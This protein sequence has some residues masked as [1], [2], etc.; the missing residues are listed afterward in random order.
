M[1]FDYNAES[2]GMYFIITGEVDLLTPSV[3]KKRLTFLRKLQVGSY[4]GEIG[5][6]LNTTR[7]L[8]VLNSNVSYST[9]AF[10]P[11]SAVERALW[12]NPKSK[13]ILN[14]KIA[15]Y[16]DVLNY[17]INYCLKRAKVMKGAGPLAHELY[18]FKIKTYEKGEYIWTPGTKLNGFMVLL[19][20]YA[21][22]LIKVSRYEIPLYCACD[23]DILGYE[24]CVAD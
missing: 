3:A 13:S 8:R 24:H 19:K 5:V 9:L 23:H 15:N 22:I 4:F 16:T 1:I 20:G 6:L 2:D 18:K 7:S 14:K 17:K 10:A 12:A 21:S 11:S